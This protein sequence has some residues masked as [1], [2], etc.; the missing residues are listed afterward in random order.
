MAPPLLCNSALRSSGLRAPKPAGKLNALTP[1]ICLGSDLR[2]GASSGWWGLSSESRWR[3]YPQGPPPQWPRPPNGK[4]G[5]RVLLPRTEIWQEILEVAE[6]R[7]LSLPLSLPLSQQS[8]VSPLSAGRPD[9]GQGSRPLSRLSE[10]LRPSRLGSRKGARVPGSVL[11]VP[12]L[13]IEMTLLSFGICLWD[14][15]GPHFQ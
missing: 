7:G 11:S 8:R 15:R 4:L 12:I 14:P 3:R 2:C 1:H 10:S 9:G 5:P 6:A 13:E